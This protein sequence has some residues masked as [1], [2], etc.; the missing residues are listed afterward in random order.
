MVHLDNQ[1][2]EDTRG[3]SGLDHHDFAQGGVGN[4]AG[5]HRQQEHRNDDAA[6]EDNPEAHPWLGKE[7]EPLEDFVQENAGQNG[8]C[9]NST[10]A[11]GMTKLGRKLSR[12]GFADASEVHD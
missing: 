10:L 4:K 9:R 3:H 8:A 5:G 2:A 6:D 12:G 7:A 11:D 1:E